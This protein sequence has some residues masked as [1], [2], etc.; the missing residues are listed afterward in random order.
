MSSLITVPFGR[1][2]KAPPLPRRRGGSNAS[3]AA[4]ALTK[5]ELKKYLETVKKG[6]SPEAELESK[7][8]DYVGNG[9]SGGY[10]DDAEVRNLF[11]DY[12]KKQVADGSADGLQKVMSTD[13]IF[14]DYIDRKRFKYDSIE[15]Q[16]FEYIQTALEAK[17]EGKD[18]KTN[19]VSLTDNERLE[20]FVDHLTDKDK[21]LVF[22][23]R[24]LE[25]IRTSNDPM[26]RLMHSVARD[27]G[28]DAAIQNTRKQLLAGESSNLTE[29]LGDRLPD[30]LK[31]E[32]EILDS[33]LG[34]DGSLVIARKSD[35][36]VLERV[37]ALEM[38]NDMKQELAGG[39]GSD[40]QGTAFEN[41]DKLDFKEFFLTAQKLAIQGETSKGDLDKHV[42]DGLS[43]I[44]AH[45][46]TALKLAEKA[47]DK[48]AIAK[49][50]KDFKLISNAILGK[51]LLPKRLAKIIRE[52][53][54]TA[55]SS[56]D[57][58]KR[59]AA[60]DIETLSAQLVDDFK[61]EL[62]AK[63]G[64]SGLKG[65]NSIYDP[66]GGQDGQGALKVLVA[67]NGIFSEQEFK[68]G[69]V[70]SNEV[71]ADQ[72]EGNRDLTG[73]T[74]SLERVI[75]AYDNTVD[76]ASDAVFNH[77]AEKLSN[78]SKI[79]KGKS[80]EKL[81]QDTDK[82]I[83]STEKDKQIDSMTDALKLIAQEASKY[84]EANAQS[85]SFEDIHK[86]LQKYI[87]ESTGFNSTE[88][89]GLWVTQTKDTAGNKVKKQTDLAKKVEAIANQIRAG[90]KTLAKDLRKSVTELADAIKTAS[91]KGEDTLNSMFADTKG[92]ARL[93][94]LMTSLRANAE[95]TES[96][97]KTLDMDKMMQI[98]DGSEGKKL[99]R[100]LEDLSYSGTKF[101]NI[102]DKPDS[103]EFGEFATLLFA[104]DNKGGIDE[105]KR[106]TALARLIK[107][108]GNGGDLSALT[109]H[110]VSKLK[111]NSVKS[112][113]ENSISGRLKDALNSQVTV[114]KTTAQATE[115]REQLKKYEA[116]LAK[117]KARHQQR[118][119]EGATTTRI[120]NAAKKVIEL[121][122][123][124]KETRQK[125]KDA[126][127][128]KV[129]LNGFV[130]QYVIQAQERKLILGE[131]Y[132]NMV[133]QLDQI[134]GHFTA[135]GVKYFS[136]AENYN[137]SLKPTYDTLI[138]ALDAQDRDSHDA[139]DKV[140]EAL[141]SDE[142]AQALFNQLYSGLQINPLK[143]PEYKTEHPGDIIDRILSFLQSTVYS[144]VL[145]LFGANYNK[146]AET[147]TTM[148]E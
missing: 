126:K 115:E 72:A 56:E 65:M 13:S 55:L 145:S 141:G 113:D 54:N 128:S 139:I 47:D 119:E 20:G 134:K 140:K 79:I 38:T 2:K 89:K 102:K 8:N 17:A 12:V 23:N 26:M 48:E 60:G 124:I 106:L 97:S 73:E 68:I 46:K 5:A 74:L 136:D 67:D 108:A 76:S 31:K 18:P 41:E 7:F 50:N 81:A 127:N 24:N 122:A 92:L 95:E 98:F 94:T 10:L 14:A 16:L 33:I 110:V 11:G 125:I 99:Q 39:E 104:K 123:S 9:V 96:L 117:A 88:K 121:E 86:A 15:A 90:K 3:L 66:S 69:Y 107:K 59:A 147:S 135:V 40:L 51:S 105:A 37:D 49:A 109:S 146:S 111:G 138:N 101:S 142:K 93:K 78:K 143:S 85:D 84:G 120:K 133:R 35:G 116:D 100:A 62:V 43:F 114:S 103:D 57:F 30:L 52:S 144:P 137:S 32:K 129:D 77:I 29:K 70:E 80:L 53:A 21:G 82:A 22:R 63:K 112:T 132:N 28:L 4:G 27:L 6:E 1:A 44:V 25:N 71:P 75:D 42:A 34:N 19:P 58:K 83:D 45:H 87:E 61:K 36:T 148:A 130:D 91:G 131:T 64:M 118:I